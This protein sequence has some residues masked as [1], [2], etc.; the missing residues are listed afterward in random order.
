MQQLLQRCVKSDTLVGVDRV[1]PTSEPSLPHLL[2]SA[3]RGDCDL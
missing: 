1:D 3:V 2:T